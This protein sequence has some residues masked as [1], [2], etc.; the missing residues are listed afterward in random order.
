MGNLTDAMTP[1]PDPICKMFDDHV[2][3]ENE[4]QTTLENRRGYLGM[5]SIGS[6]CQ[7]KE[8]LNFVWADDIYLGPRTLRKFKDGHE[9]EERVFKRLREMDVEVWDLDENGKQFACKAPNTGGF[10]RGHLD[11]VC[12]GLPSFDAREP[13]LVD[14]KICE[15]TKFKK[16]VELYNSG[17]DK[18]LLHWNPDYYGQANMYMLDKD[19]MYGCYL[20]FTPGLLDC[21]PLRVKRDLEYAHSLHDKAR[22]IIFCSDIKDLQRV[23]ETEDHQDC[24]FC[25]Y[26]D[27][28]Y[29]RKL[30]KITCRTCVH[31][32]P[33]HDTEDGIWW[34]N[35]HKKNLDNF[36]PCQGGHL[37]DPTLLQDWAVVVDIDDDEN[38]IKY[39]N[40]FTEKLF[41][42]S[43]DD[44]QDN[45]YDSF[46]LKELYVQSGPRKIL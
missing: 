11:A 40:K 44:N 36:R 4:E 14:V 43:N 32:Q 18:P 10:L 22:E 24:F 46:S 1:T 37:Y 2:L 45:N 6:S 35:N 5:S 27:V 34:C 26:K 39:H 41:M 3:W 13:I 23:S 16:A 21:V 31:S 42:S 29:G 30:P 12:K 25:G 9:S 17:I 38:W 7:R 20:I 19:L 15:E 28:C 33:R 8:Y